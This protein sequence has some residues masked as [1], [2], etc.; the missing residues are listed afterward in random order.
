MANLVTTLQGPI[1]ALREKEIELLNDIALVLSD[2][3]EEDRKR[4][5]DMAQDLRDMFFMVAVIGEFNAGKSTFVNALIGEKLLPMGITP[6]TEYIELIRYN[7]IASRTPVIRADGLRE[8]SHPN[9]GAPGVAIV[10]TPGTGSIFQKHE[11]TAKQFL[12][13]SDLVIFLL[14]AKQA[15]AE[16]E[17]LYLDLARQYG[18]KI[19]LV[20]N[21]VDLLAPAEQA[22]VRRFIEMQVKQT[23]NLEPPIFMIS[24]RD[25]LNAMGGENG[26]GS[27]PGSVGAVRAYLRGLYSETPPAKQKLLVQ[28]ETVERIL[29]QYLQNIQEKTGLV[30]TDI[31]RVKDIQQELQRQSIGLETQMKEAGANIDMVLEGVRARGLAFINT[32][33]TMRNLGR[34][35]DKQKLQEEF[36]ENVIGRSLKEISEYAGE[37]INAVVDQSRL[38]WRSVLDRLNQLKDLMEQEPGGLDAGI[39][40]EQRTGL[41]EAI[42]IAE[43]E[44]KM[45]S[46]GTV[47]NEL[48]QMFDTNMSNFQLTAALTAGGLITAIVAVLTPGALVGM[49]AA[50]LAL[51]AFIAGAAV[52]AVFGIPAFRSFRSITRET[53]QAFNERVDLLIKNYH[54]A[55][56][57]LTKKERNRLTQ[58]GNQILMPIFSRLEVL[59][60][61]YGDQQAQLSRYQR[62]IA[63]LRGRIENVQ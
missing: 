33:L 29:Q 62:E 2:A 25:A 44:L 32:Y 8:W 55:L 58:Y 22:E 4:I 56:D 27:D 54:T 43:A 63:D 45:Y 46:S 28:L 11:T 16:S 10:D 6:T 5:Q 20:V 41:Q 1:A 42:R 38:Y 31:V 40:A 18:K 37:Y 48:K 26:T 39:Y 23:L 13:R 60:K 17:R 61:R 53:K 59:S 14:S 12:H 34:G 50:P 3:G 49:G 57:E 21:Q 24:A 30:G 19:I 51:P 47:V 36:Q 9:T 35:I 15:F 7:E 52:A